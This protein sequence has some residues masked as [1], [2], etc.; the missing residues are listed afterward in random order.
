MPDFTLTDLLAAS[1]GFLLFALFGFVPGYVVAWSTDLFAFRKQTL[2]ARLSLAVC[3]SFGL[4]PVLA[5]LAGRLSFSAQWIAFALVWLAGLGIL[6]SWLRSRGLPSIRIQPPGRIFAAIVLGWFLLGLFSLVDLQWGRRLY[7]SVVS[8]DY[9]LR[10]AITA[11]IAH[12]GIPPANPYF[13]PGQAFPLRYH[14]FWMIPCALVERLGSPFVSA[15][16]ATIAGTLWAGLGLLAIV[17]LYLRFFT[18]ARPS[19]LRRR[20]LIGLSLLMVTGLDIIPN[21]L[22]D[23]FRQPLPEPEWW[24]TQISS[25]I[26]TVL[27][28]PHHAAA[29]IAGLTGILI[30]WSAGRFSRWPSVSALIAGLCLASSAGCSMYVAAILGVWLVL[31]TAL[32]LWKGWRNETRFLLVTGAVAL[33]AVAPHLLALRG[34]LSADS[35]A[36]GPPFTFKVREFILTDLFKPWIHGIFWRENLIDL[37][38]LPLNYFM[39]L[40]LFFVVAVAAIRHYRKTRRPLRRYELATLTL[41]GVSVFICSFLRSSLLPG[42][43]LGWRGFLPAQF[44]LL[45]WAVDLLDRPWPLRAHRSLIRALIVLGVAS[46]LYEA[47]SLRLYPIAYDLWDIPRFRWFAMDRQLGGRTYALRSAYDQLKTQLPSTAIVQHNPNGI[48]GNLPWGLYADRPAAAETPGC[49][50]L[51]GGDPKLCASVIA[52]LNPVFD[53]SLPAPDLDRVCSQWSI[54][55]IL[56]KDTDPAWSAG[57]SWIRQRPPILSNPFVRVY[58]CGAANPGRSRLSG[59]PAPLNYNKGPA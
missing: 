14:Y 18:P 36:A 5:Y 38:F 48:P 26:T 2:G 22:R 23:L 47:A 37:L 8:Y 56:I 44:V 9:T 3:L 43:D 42:N 51:F 11:S 33:L 31:W 6:I 15:R 30:I 20:T 58:L 41:A 29:L 32:S 12:T 57:A 4:T 40:G 13:S 1:L 59:G 19:R 28:V 17:S 35:G 50:T 21:L 55:A 45:L 7:F 39:E 27:F 34:S 10:T 54:S 49:G 16:Q 46:S 52:S 25:W 24:N 53:G